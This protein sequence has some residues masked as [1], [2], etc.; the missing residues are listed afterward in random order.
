MNTDS[1]RFSILHYNR[2][3][4]LRL[5]LSARAA[6]PAIALLAVIHRAVLAGLF[7]IRLV[8]RKTHRAN[9]CREDRHQDFRVIRHRLI[10]GTRRSI[11]NQN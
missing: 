9:R 5:H 8:R 6:L 3:E 7:A 11:A 1:N 4:K 10:L 2:S